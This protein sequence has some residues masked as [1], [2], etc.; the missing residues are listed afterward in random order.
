MAKSV[1]RRVKELVEPTTRAYLVTNW[2]QS[3]SAYTKELNA[4]IFKK[5]GDVGALC[6]RYDVAAD[7]FIK[8]DKKRD[9]AKKLFE[10]AFTS[11]EKIRKQ[12][13]GLNKE[14]DEIVADEAASISTIKDASKVDDV[15]HN[16]EEGLKA[17]QDLNKTRKVIFDKKG[18]L[19]E[20]FAKC[21]ADAISSVKKE[22]EAAKAGMNSTNNELNTLE[23]Q[24]RS[25]VVGYQKTAIEMDKREIADA[26]RG[27]LSSFG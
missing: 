27:V 1:E 23:A 10:T 22:V 18:K 24:I 26:V 4:P 25:I 8:F 5:L 11:L 21:Q 6:K 14:L 15:L 20:D 3:T 7:N 9:E 16:W 2:N 13:D 17:Q 19:G 12:S